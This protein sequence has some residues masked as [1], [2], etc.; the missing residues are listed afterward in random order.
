MPSTPDTTV[1]RTNDTLGKRL[2]LERGEAEVTDLNGSSRTSDEDVVTLEVAVD[3][4]RRSTVKEQQTFEDLS[5]P[6]LEN[7]QVDPPEPLD[8]PAQ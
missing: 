6:V 7:V 4:W 3:H 5:T 8:V 2:V 1:S